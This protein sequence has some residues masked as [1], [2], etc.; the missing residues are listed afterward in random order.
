M[1]DKIICK[2]NFKKRDSEAAYLRSF[3]DPTL[4]RKSKAKMQILD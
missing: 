1:A 3:S 2:F 4:T